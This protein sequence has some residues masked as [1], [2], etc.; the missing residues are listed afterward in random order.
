MVDGEQTRK[1]EQEKK[2][3]KNRVREREKIEDKQQK[4]QI[5]YAALIIL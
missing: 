2:K 5:I 4:R 3:K 1:I